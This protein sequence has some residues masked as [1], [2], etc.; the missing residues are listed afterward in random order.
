MENRIFESNKK[1]IE[2]QKIDENIINNV[3]VNNFSPKYLKLKCQNKLF[4]LNIEFNGFSSELI[5]CFFSFSHKTP[6]LKI[7]DEEIKK[8]IPSHNYKL[9]FSEQNK[10]KNKIGEQKDFFFIFMCLESNSTITIKITYNFYSNSLEKKSDLSP[11]LISQKIFDQMKNGDITKIN[12]KIEFFLKNKSELTFLYHKANEILKCKNIES[13]SP[14]KSKEKVQTPSKKFDISKEALI[15]QEQFD[16]NLLIQINEGNLNNLQMSP[17]LPQ[18]HRNDHNSIENQ[19]EIKFNASEKKDLNDE[20]N[21]FNQYNTIDKK[22]YK[23]KSKSL[24]VQQRKNYLFQKKR[25]VK[26]IDYHRWDL[27]KT[28][29]II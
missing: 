23:S 17:I 11:R 10:N 9:F 25:I 4:P 28:R 8:I 26:A 7:N 15:N 2:H 5:N 6:S 19:Y 22:H 20:I 12:Q 18:T 1:E 14:K 21:N 16:K 3:N 27:K 24:S 13:T 29:V